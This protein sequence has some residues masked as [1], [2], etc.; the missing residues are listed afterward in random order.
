MEMPGMSSSMDRM[1]SG[2]LDSATGQ[3]YDLEFIAQMIPHHAGALEMARDA[4]QRAERQ[5]IK[6]LA[7]TLTKDQAEEI[8]QMRSWQAAW[9]K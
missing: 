6:K 3:A 2:K 8:N 1:N 7:E 4:S 9:A 5:E